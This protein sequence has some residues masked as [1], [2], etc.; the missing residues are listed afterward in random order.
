[1][2]SGAAA[3][4]LQ[5]QVLREAMLQVLLTHK[6]VRTSALD[7]WPWP[8]EPSQEQS[9]A[10]SSAVLNMY[11]TKTLLRTQSGLFDWDFS[12]EWHGL[13]MPARLQ[14]CLQEMTSSTKPSGGDTVSVRVWGLLSLCF[15]ELQMVR[16]KKISESFV[17]GYRLD[18]FHV[19]K[20]MEMC[21][22]F[23]L[24]M[25]HNLMWNLM[26]L[27]VAAGRIWIM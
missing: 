20:Y 16:N 6:P 13:L 8:S 18:W 7:V 17:S 10:R 3:R 9:D 19:A 21:Y 1:M 14:V 15:T 11:W 4:R 23:F 2:L 24:N 5:P 12:G 27:M 25:L 22:V 26:H